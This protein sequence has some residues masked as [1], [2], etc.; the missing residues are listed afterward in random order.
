VDALCCNCVCF[1]YLC[2]VQVVDNWYPG[3]AKKDKGVLLMVTASKEG[4][5][6]G[7][8]GF[9]AV[10][11]HRQQHDAAANTSSWSS[12]HQQQQQSQQAPAAAAA[13]HGQPMSEH[14][15]L[16]RQSVAGS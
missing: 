6:T 12:R 5:V 2:C 15:M 10:R 8:E 3:D 14:M 7:G 11:G 1:L 16:W 9:M 13:L 4:A